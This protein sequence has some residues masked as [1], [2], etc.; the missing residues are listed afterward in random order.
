MWSPK[1]FPVR[2]SSVTGDGAGAE[3]A[4]S[5]SGRV[6]NSRDNSLL[7]E[8]SAG[9]GATSLFARRGTTGGG[10]RGGGPNNNSNNNAPAGQESTAA[11]DSSCDDDDEDGDTDGEGH[12]DRTLDVMG[13]AGK[14][15]SISNAQEDVA[16]KEQMR[17]FDLAVRMSGEIDIADHKRHLKRHK[18][19]F[20]GRQAVQWMLASR[21]AA[22]LP[23]AMASG[24]A[25]IKAGLVKGVTAGRSFQNRSFLYRFNVAMDPGV[26]AARW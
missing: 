3:A 19:C 16:A 6:Q 25:L 10:G 26:Q 4:K 12:D 8:A 13:A 15:D 24:A 9:D 17:L 18:A 5:A 22:N 14:I 7:S 11:D 21:V 23:E 2:K 1:V 20:T